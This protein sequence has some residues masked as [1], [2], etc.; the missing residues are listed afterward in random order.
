MQPNR[1][2]ESPQAT[3]I[4]LLQPLISWQRAL[5]PFS[6]VLLDKSLRFKQKVEPGVE[7]GEDEIKDHQGDHT[8]C[9]IK[10]EVE[11]EVEGI[12]LEDEEEALVMHHMFNRK[13][14]RI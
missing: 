7:G 8:I 3:R 5:P 2:F 14:G 9:T 12:T 13:I 4:T 6:K 1:L 11:N 10:A